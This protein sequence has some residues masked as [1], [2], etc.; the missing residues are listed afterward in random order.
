MIEELLNNLYGLSACNIKKS[1][2]GA[3]SDT[4]FITSGFE[5]YVMKFPCESEM[6]NPDAEPLICDFLLKKN[7]PVCEFIKNNLGEYISIDENGRKF[8]LQKFA[9][10]KMFELNTAPRW[11]L[12][13]SAGM[14]G[15]IHSALTDYKGLSDGIGKNFFTYMTPES[16]LSSYKRTAIIANELG[17]TNIT[18]DL[19]YRIELMG[20]FP[21]YEI[22]LDRL[23]CQ[24]T[25][26]DYFISQLICGEKKINA[27]IDWTT[28]CVH[29]VVFEI[30]RSYVYA[31]PSYING[32]IN[33]HEFVEY[34]FEYLKFA[35][36]N[37][38][39]IEMM[40]KLFYYQISVCDYYGQYYSSAADN[41]HI[42]LHQAVFSTKL[43][44]W[45]DK[46]IDSLTRALQ[47]SF[48]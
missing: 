21:V 45:F 25:H 35:K 16:A 48:K 10:G 3:G 40:A 18:E 2:V 42:Y 44:K 4:Y 5:K 47:D 28:A 19:S 39:D 41:R 46:N 8:H 22:D 43:M 34:V 37:P 27:V 24:S 31:A 9:E 1:A 12:R 32:E 26:G 11:L 30:I 13:E 17:D 20:R 15:K 36:L 6:N 38:Y 23:S 14:L 29:P 7:L 33:I